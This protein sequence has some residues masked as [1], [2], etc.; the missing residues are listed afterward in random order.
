MITHETI[1]DP[2]CGSSIRMARGASHLVHSMN[3]NSTVRSG[4]PVGLVSFLF[5]SCRSNKRLSKKGRR[6][7]A[8][9]LRADER[10][11]KLRKA[12]GSRKQAV[13][14]RY[15]NGETRHE[16]VMSSYTEFIGVRREPGEL[17]HLSS[18][19]K[20]KQK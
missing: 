11:D 13:I 16:E 14:R 18:R 2:L 15:L 3:S 6:A 9:A 20:R 1:S 17:K 10:R 7:D 19:R 4:K 8:L 5:I 12:S